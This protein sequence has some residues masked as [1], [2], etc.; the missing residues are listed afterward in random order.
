MINKF[1]ILKKR[2]LWGTYRMPCVMKLPHQVVAYLPRV[3][4]SR[5]TAAELLLVPLLTLTAYA[6]PVA[7]A[8][9]KGTVET[10]AS[11]LDKDGHVP[12]HPQVT[13]YFCGAAAME[14]ELDCNA[15]RNQNAAI[16][17]MLGAGVRGVAPG[18]AVVDGQPQPCFMG[19]PFC[20]PPVIFNG[21]QVVGGAQSFIYG[22]VHWLN[23]YNGL[24]YV[25]PSYPAGLGTSIDGVQVGLNLMDSPGNAAGPHNYIS[26]N[27]ANRDWANRTMADAL[28]QLGIAAA[29]VIKHSAH[30]VC[31]VGVRTDK[32]PV[33]N[34]DFKIYGFYIRDPW[35]GYKNAVDP[36]GA[37]K[38]L[39]GLGENKFCST[40]VNPNRLPADED[41]D[42][43][44][45]LGL[46]P[47]WPA[48]GAGLGYKFEV[49]PIGPVP[50]DTGN[51]GQY[52]SVPAPS[53][54]LTNAPLTAL[55]ALAFATNELA[56]D[57]FLKVQPGLTNGTWDLANAMIVRYP[58]DGTNQGDWLLPYEAAGGTNQVTGFVLVDIET[59]DVDEV[60]WMNPGDVVPSMTVSNVQTME[61]D[62]FAGLVPDDNQAEPQLSMQM[63][64]TN[65]VVLTWPASAMIT[66][67]L[68]RSASL[69]TP[70]WVTL[71]NVPA[72]V[73]SQNQV[74]LPAPPGPSFFRL[75]GP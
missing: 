29:A 57:A 3:T 25:N 62:E 43:L 8:G 31:V 18:A 40:K 45:D 66:Y 51:N 35:E 26:Y 68:Q 67:S 37:L 71:T 63:T 53:P 23:T 13:A 59:G 69:S 39:P 61:T 5:R 46:G 54:I 12:Y 17:T 42:A 75:S 58:G 16:D 52:T 36:N 24:S 15:I 34:G 64:S 74:T 4:G 65:T 9:P 32:V 41:W 30:W 33:A 47:P 21:N 49:E 44:F 10:W 2:G 14:M 60:N 48:Y 20:W 6:Q 70:S 19:H 73:N 55:A 38:L 56:A 50:L 28:A 11:G 27:V 72:V 1:A 7:N 22:L